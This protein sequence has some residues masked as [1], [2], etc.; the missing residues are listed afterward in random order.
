MSIALCEV[1]SKQNRRA[2]GEE[3]HHDRDRIVPIRQ[4]EK[5]TTNTSNQSSQ[6]GQSRNRP[7]SIKADAVL[8]AETRPFI[9]LVGERVD[10]VAACCSTG[11]PVSIR[12]V[13]PSTAQS[14]DV[15][16]VVAHRSTYVLAQFHTRLE[17]ED[18]ADLRRLPRAASPV[19]RVTR[20]ATRDEEKRIATA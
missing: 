9:D 17:A 16:G 6:S 15:W 18:W 13:E 4:D 7:D 20:D 3:S 19:E 1:V 5:R 14:T 11:I 12:P 10:V 8:L 2:R